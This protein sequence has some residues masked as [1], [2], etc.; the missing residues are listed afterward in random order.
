M[1]SEPPTSS[2][3]S[4]HERTLVQE[5]YEAGRLMRLAREHRLFTLE[6]FVER[7]ARM[8]IEEPNELAERVKQEAQETL[9]TAREQEYDLLGR[10]DGP[11]G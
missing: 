10:G 2:S 3:M 8:K 7:V 4:E 6:T 9:V 1:A 5:G 11:V